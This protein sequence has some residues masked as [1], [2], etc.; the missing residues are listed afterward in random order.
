VSAVRILGEADAAAL[1]AFLLRHADSS[2]FLRANAWAWGLEDRGRAN[3]STH[4]AAFE[5]GR[6]VAVAAHS[7]TGMLVVQAPA[8]LEAVVRAAV[9]HSRR[10]LAG[11]NGPWS[12]VVA[13]RSALGLDRSPAFLDSHEILYALE[14]ARLVVPEPL[15]AG[16][17]RCRRVRRDEIDLI[18]GWRADYARETL[19]RPDTPALP[20]RSR[21]ETERLH[22][23]GRAFVA[24]T[25][26]DEPLAFSA[27]NA[28]LPDAVQVGGVWTPPARRGRGY[29]RA[30]VAG[31]LLDA[32]ARGVTRGVLFT[33]QENRPAQRAY[34]ALGFQVVGDYGLLGFSEPQLV[35]ISS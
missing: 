25:A 14:L 1:S 19:S 30:A 24:A 6:I 4:A 27:F 21:Q 28:V 32:R 2:M 26:T 8:H 16:R 33:A 18:A 31:S 22:A 29:A 9:G 15:A 17:L 13:A 7:W 3:Q 23:E 20:I 12:Q 35:R 10:P 34:E 11:I 5:E